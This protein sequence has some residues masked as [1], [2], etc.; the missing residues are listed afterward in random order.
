MS[1]VTQKRTNPVEVLM[2]HDAW[3]RDQLIAYQRSQLR[4]VLQHA[5][6]SSPYYREVL[7]RDALDPRLRLEDLPTL[8]KLA[9]MSEF[10]RIV[11]DRRLRLAGL[12]AHLGGSDP[13][14][15]F[16]REFHVFTTSGTT[17][18]RGVFPQSRAEFAQWVAGCRRV[19]TRFD[20]LFATRTIGIA[21]P[22]PLHI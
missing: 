8:S 16:A 11:T 5:V 4:E 18:R 1:M 20:V 7:G 14:A 6:S 12:E 3:S 19:L 21:A 17:G 15:L 10:D 22:T 13:G 2:A 9:L